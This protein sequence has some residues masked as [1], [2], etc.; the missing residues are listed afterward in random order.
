[1]SEQ[2]GPPHFLILGS[3]RVPQLA[4]TLP[5]FIEF[6]SFV[7]LNSSWSV[8]I[9]SVANVFGVYLMVVYWNQVPE[10]M[11]SAATIDEAGEVAI[12]LR[13]GLPTVLFGLTTLLLISFVVTWN[14][15]FRPLAMLNKRGDTRS[16]WE[17]RRSF[18]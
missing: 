3:A 18:P 13:I 1:L 2:W 4:T 11:F 8:I 5:L 16:S 14:N 15:D 9:P 10:E 6:K 7:I 17:S 12:L